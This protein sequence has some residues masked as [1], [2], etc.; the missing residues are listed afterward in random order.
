MQVATPQQAQETHAF[1]R[2]WFSENISEE[3]AKSIRILYG[4][5]F[6]GTMQELNR[7]QCTF[8][9]VIQLG[10]LIFCNKIWRH[11]PH[12]GPII[13]FSDFDSD[14][15]LDEIILSTI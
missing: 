9:H 11:T 3:V 14:S 1:V 13:S 8:V 2:K 10:S 12:E 7:L 4:N 15:V 6:L 5:G